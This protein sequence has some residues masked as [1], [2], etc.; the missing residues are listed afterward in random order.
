M[1]KTGDGMG[2]KVALASNPTL[3]AS[4]QERLMAYEESDIYRALASNG[5]LTPHGCDTLYDLGGY[6]VELAHNP[7]L[8]LDLFQKLYH[9]GEPAVLN[10]LASNPSTPIDLLYQLSL[11]RRYERSVQTNPTFGKHIQTHN[12]GWN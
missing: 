7:S 9:K 12:I 11:D 10:T 1:T 2:A 8:S 3:T 5:A 4:M 6:T